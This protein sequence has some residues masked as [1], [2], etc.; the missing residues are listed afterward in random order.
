VS[1]KR[2]AFILGFILLSAL[3]A[4]ST[5][6]N[7]A[8]TYIDLTGQNLMA[9]VTVPSAN[10]RSGPSTNDR[11]V[12][13]A[14][15]GTR[16]TVLGAAGTG[17]DRWFLIQRT[18][19]DTA[20]VSAQVVQVERAQIAADLAPDI[21]T[22]YI[23]LDT[24]PGFFNR[25]DDLLTIY[26]NGFRGLSASGD[27][28]R[29]IGTLFL[30]PEIDAEDVRP[31]LGNE[32]AIVNLQCLSSTMS[33]FLMTESLQETPRPS[34]VIMAQT[35]DET[36]TRQFINQ[37][38]NS[39][40][41]RNAPRQQVTYNGITYTLLN[42]PSMPNYNPDAQPVAMG[43][44]GE[45]AVFTQGAGSFNAII[46]SATGR[47]PTL[48]ASPKFRDVYYQLTGQPFLKVYVAPGLFCPVHEPILYRALLSDV[49]TFGDIDL[50]GVDG[51]NLSDAELQERLIALLDNAFNGY[52][53]SYGDQG[54][55]MAIN[56]ASGYNL[57]ALVE[58]TGLP[59]D[60]IERRIGQGG[61]ELFGF[62]RPS[63]MQGLS[64]GRT[65]A[66]YDQLRAMAAAT[67]D[68]VF[69][70]ATGLSRDMLD[71]FE[72]VITMGF[73]DYPLFAGGGIASRPA[74]FLLILETQTDAL[75][76]EAM[77]NFVASAMQQP[78]AVDS[79][80]VVEGVD[81]W[82]VV[83]STNEVVEVAALDNFVIVTTGGNLN[84]VLQNG[85]Q[86]SSGRF[87]PDWI[88][89]AGLPQAQALARNNPDAAPFVAYLEMGRNLL[90]GG[91][92]FQP[93][94]VMMSKPTRQIQTTGIDTRIETAA[95]VTP[96]EA[97]LAELGLLDID[98]S[99]LDDEQIASLITIICRICNTTNC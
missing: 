78:G 90:R 22:M 80:T 32:V 68:V 49:Y 50:P 8:P 44:V 11:V 85:R 51:T 23:S 43:I 19:S 14:L 87:Y 38:V 46:D 34:V 24:S 59:A 29:M 52:G 97:L 12:Y 61:L 40:T 33:D 81:A 3:L 56:V 31:W 91:N 26:N 28:D 64:F 75:A 83:N 99:T 21:S 66:D 77:N 5:F 93:E 70:N 13:G 4:G 18:T 71:W 15:N 72:G 82:R 74:Y 6:A 36:R 39:G 20:W 30:N 94:A 55:R 60:E 53:V 37:V 86:T 76:T 89:L 96:P 73:I 35:V 7:E 98:P 45:F 41:L 10:L 67:P 95:V 69:E 25:M 16:L 1:A 9:T 47:T 92:T 79:S 54:D 17:A 27:V 42:D 58:I 65:T 84:R 57:Q 48:G 2:I 62:L 88:L 63:A